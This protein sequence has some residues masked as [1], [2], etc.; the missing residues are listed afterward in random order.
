VAY[1]ISNV[2]RPVVGRRRTEDEAVGAAKLIQA[3]MIYWPQ[4]KPRGLR[5]FHWPFGGQAAVNISPVQNI[6]DLHVRGGGFAAFEASV[7]SALTQSGGDG[8]TV[9]IERLWDLLGDRIAARQE[10]LP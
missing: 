6:R 5:Q 9:P 2:C 1:L 7:F 3:H 8:K 4:T 10:L